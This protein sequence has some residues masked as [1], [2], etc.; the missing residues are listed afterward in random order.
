MIIPRAN[1]DLFFGHRFSFL[2]ENAG[3]L[4]I[5]MMVPALLIASAFLLVLVRNVRVSLVLRSLGKVR[6]DSEDQFKRV[7][8]MA[9]VWICT[10][11]VFLI[12]WEP[13]MMYYRVFYAPAC[14][15]LAAFLLSNYHSF[16]ARYNGQDLPD[17]VPSGAALL[18]VLALALFNFAFYISPG[19][20]LEANAIVATAHEAQNVWDDNTII[21][22]A[23]PNSADTAFEYFN[24]KADWRRLPQSDIQALNQE[25]DDLHKSAKSVWLNKGA[26]SYADR[27]WLARYARGREVKLELE[28]APA[29]YIE[30]APSR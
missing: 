20:R 4:E 13:S 9:V 17:K 25:I 14:I 3:Y 1:L 19:M 24:E 22:Y 5:L 6:Q 21:Y 23:K 7:V 29:H 18:A 16:V 2:L 10:Y 15:F 8:P 30:L 27:K 28:H 12:F 26:F 11:S